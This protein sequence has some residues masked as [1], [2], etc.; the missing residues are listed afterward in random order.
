MKHEYL[1]GSTAADSWIGCELI[2]KNDAL[3]ECTIR[4]HDY[5]V[6]GLVEA[7]V[8]KCRVRQAVLTS[9]ENKPRRTNAEGSYD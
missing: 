8:E 7:S 5:F 4:Y 6:D 9:S 3:D 2:C 1:W